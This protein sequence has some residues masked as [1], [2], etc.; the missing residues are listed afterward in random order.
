MPACFSG[1]PALARSRS[2]VEFADLDHSP[3]DMRA[4][5][6]TVQPAGR[7]SP[8]DPIQSGFWP[9]INAKPHPL[10]LPS[11]PIMQLLTP[12][13]AMGTHQ[14]SHHSYGMAIK[15]LIRFLTP[16]RVQC[17]SFQRR[18]TSF[19]PVPAQYQFFWP[20]HP[21]HSKRSNC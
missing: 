12:P 2:S 21:S 6:I 15:V 8:P 11:A 19:H 3:I 5:I 4:A 18:Y 17:R 20:V 7:P 10:C 13:L 1:Q 9:G 14:I 16:Q